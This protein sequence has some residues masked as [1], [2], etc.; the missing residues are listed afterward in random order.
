MY[1]H[2]SFINSLN[3]S[4]PMYELV[5][6][7]LFHLF[8]QLWEWPRP[9]SHFQS[10]RSED[11]CWPFILKNIERMLS[12]NSSLFF[13]SL[14]DEIW[15]ICE[16]AGSFA[17]QSQFSWLPLSESSSILIFEVPKTCFCSAWGLTISFPTDLLVWT[18]ELLPVWPIDRLASL[19]L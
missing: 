9:F 4:V 18:W 13:A 14:S 11:D 6:A 2:P 12:I 19:D 3:L 17:L 10:Y 7:L 15:E 1:W 8:R 16:G 5:S